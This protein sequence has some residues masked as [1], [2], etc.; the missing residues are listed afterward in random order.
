VKE[1]AR[2]EWCR[3]GKRSEE[4]T[5]GEAG[6]EAERNVNARECKRGANNGDEVVESCAAKMLEFTSEQRA[7]KRRALRE[8]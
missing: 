1:C 2:V 3:K 6:A 5:R 7:A 8:R 4:V